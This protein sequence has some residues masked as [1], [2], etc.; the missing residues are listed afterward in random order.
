MKPD[1]IKKRLMPL[2]RHILASL[3]LLLYSGII[4]ANQEISIDLSENLLKVDQPEMFYY[5]GEQGFSVFDAGAKQLKF[6]NWDF[7]NTRSMPLLIGEAP[8]EI[9]Q[10][11]RATSCFGPNIYLIGAAEKQLKIYTNSGSY[12][13]SIPLDIMPLF[14]TVYQNKLFI[15]NLYF[16]AQQKEPTVLCKVYCPNTGLFETDILLK[17]HLPLEKAYEGN[18]E[19]IGR[20]TSFG[21]G[22][23][24]IYLVNG[25]AGVLIELNWAGKIISTKKL[26]YP[27]KTEIKKEN[28]ATIINN[29]DV[30]ID[31]RVNGTDVYATFLRN[32][33]KDKKDGYTIYKT[34]VLRIPQKGKFSEKIIDGCCVLIGVHKGML[35]LFNTDDYVAS[36]IKM[37]GW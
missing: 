4:G 29:L 23:N 34:H 26:P 15:F 11:L 13:K 25:A 2:K 20:S 30:Y 27:E 12:L 3:L 24:S 36:S 31:M 33:G 14:M 7:K 16:A 6:F 28:G 17:Q 32:M 1:S 5:L 8:G 18:I 10:W 35:Y 19:M 37:V 9:K 21:I 22:T